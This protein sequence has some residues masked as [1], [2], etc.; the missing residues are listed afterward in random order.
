VEATAGS[1]IEAANRLDRAQQARAQEDARTKHFFVLK[2]RQQL[3]QQQGLC[4][5]FEARVAAVEQQLAHL[6][7]AGHA[8]AHAHVPMMAAASVTAPMQYHISPPQQWQEVYMPH[9]MAQQQHYQHHMPAQ[10]Q[11]APAHHHVMAHAQ[12]HAMSQQQIAQA[13]HHGAPHPQHQPQA[14]AEEP[15]GEPE[16][17]EDEEGTSA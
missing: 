3:K 1:A 9:P 16:E 8:P 15:V 7:A 10:Y 11:M 14:P 2:Q 13:A 6:A 5:D 17:D 4:C 12:M